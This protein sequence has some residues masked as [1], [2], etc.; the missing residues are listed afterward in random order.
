MKISERIE[1]EILDVEGLDAIIVTDPYN[2]R[3]LSGSDSEGALLLTRESL[4]LITDSRYTLAAKKAASPA[5]FQVIEYT[6]QKPLKKNIA[7]IL[8]SEGLSAVGYEDGN[9][10]VSEFKKYTEVLNGL[11]LHPLGDKLD[12]MRAVKTKEE[13]ICLEKAESIGDIAFK[14]ILPY[15]KPGVTELEL[16]ARIEFEMKMNGAEGLSFDTIVASG[17]NSAIPHHRPCEKKIEKGDFVT[18]DFGCIYHGYCSDMTRTVVVGKASDEQKK[19]YSTVLAAQLAGL[20]ALKPGVSGAQ[21]DAV[22]RTIIDEAGYK[23]KFGHG[24]GHGVGLFIHEDPRL[25]P[26]EKRLMKAGYIETVEPGIYLPGKYGVRLED[27]VV[28]TKS[29]ARILTKK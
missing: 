23:G 18:M 1:T 3:Y 16:T 27:T 20:N 26:S 22:A 15:I 8:K 7:A 2:F 11:T 29:G 9:L 4:Y 17:I 10:T 19:V 5:G 25:S 14:N 24:L 13:I 6:T 28:I 21:V 12:M